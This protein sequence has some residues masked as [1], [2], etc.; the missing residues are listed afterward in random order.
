LGFI[1]QILNGMHH[2]EEETMCPRKDDTL[3][4]CTK[5]VLKSVNDRNT[6]Y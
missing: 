6:Q 2:G 4:H 1:R 5:F 3:W